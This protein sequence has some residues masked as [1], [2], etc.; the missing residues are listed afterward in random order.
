MKGI[1]KTINGMRTCSVPECGKTYPATTEYFHRAH[2]KSKNGNIIWKGL[3]PECKFC[4]NKKRREKLSLKKR[5][6][7]EPNCS[8]ELEKGQHFCSECAQIRRDLSNITSGH[9][10]DQKPE[11]IE[12]KSKYHRKYYKDHKKEITAYNKEYR[13]KNKKKEIKQ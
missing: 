2:V 9:T 8:R 11:R 3:R 4:R 7:P 5:Y 1:P 12:S 13:K 6:C 10:H